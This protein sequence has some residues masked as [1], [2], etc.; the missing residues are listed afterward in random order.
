MSTLSPISPGRSWY[1]DT[2]GQRPGYEPLD[3]DLETDVAIVGAAIPGFP[4]PG[5]LAAAGVGVRSSRPTATV[6]APR[7]AKAAIGIRQRGC[8]GNSRPSSA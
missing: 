1:E 5:A 2:A 6:T 3:G 8:R 7:A 4:R